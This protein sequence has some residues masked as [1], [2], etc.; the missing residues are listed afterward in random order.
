MKID[1]NFAEWVHLNNK[2]QDRNGHQTISGPAKNDS[3][4]W[5]THTACDIT[6]NP[7]IIQSASY[8]LCCVK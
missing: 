5:Q 3:F 1:E 8:F 2:E 7:K 6:L 4:P